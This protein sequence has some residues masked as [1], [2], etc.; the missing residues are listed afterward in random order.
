MRTN[1]QHE[2]AAQ[3][4]LALIEAAVPGR[5]NG[6]VFG[7]GAWSARHDTALPTIN[8]GAI[9][10]QILLPA[11]G[12]KIYVSAY[13]ENGGIVAGGREGPATVEGAEGAA[14]RLLGDLNL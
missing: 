8:G 2:R 3:A 6:V 14:R 12:E 1:P 13:S 10:V 5:N 11:A 4:A 7:M 9:N